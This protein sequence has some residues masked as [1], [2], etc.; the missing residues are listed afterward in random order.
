MGLQISIKI[1]SFAYLV[2]LPLMVV[3]QEGKKGTL[4]WRQPN[5]FAE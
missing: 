2:M 3:L 5:F 1:K 4:A